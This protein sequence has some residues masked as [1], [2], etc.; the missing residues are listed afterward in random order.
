MEMPELVMENIIWFSDFRSVLKLRQVCRKFR[1]FID[2]LNDSKLPDSKFANIEVISKKDENEITLFLVEP[3]DSHRSFHSIEYSE[4]ENSRSFNEKIT[5]LGNSNIVDVAIRDLEWVLK[6]QK[7]N[8]NRLHFEFDDFQLQNDSSLYTLPFK[9][10]NMLNVSGRKIKTRELSIKTYNKSHIMSIL[11]FADSETLKTLDFCS[12]DPE[13]EIE[14]D[15][16]AKT[17]QWKKANTLKCDFHLL[18]LNVEDICH[19]SSID[20]KVDSITAGDLDFLRKAYISSSNFERLR[21]DLKLF[22]EQVEL[23]NIWGPA[24]DSQLAIIWYFRIKDSEEKVLRIEI[25][26]YNMIPRVYYATCFSIIELRSVLNGAI[27]HDY[28]E[29]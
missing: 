2:D 26:Y 9:L 4:S 16:I 12:F 17:E 22:N 13:M 27:L 18:N 28:N 5:N 23:S 10:S 20:L 6:F 14:I 8:L 11:P 15:E 29:N 21:F 24:F 7:S 19:F 25:F 3:K 1:D